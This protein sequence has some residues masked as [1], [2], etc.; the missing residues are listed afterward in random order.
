MVDF[1][2]VAVF[3]LQAVLQMRAGDAT[4][5]PLR[6]HVAH[7]PPLLPATLA[8]VPNIDSGIGVVGDGPVVAQCAIEAFDAGVA[9]F[10]EQEP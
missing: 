9:E 6:E 8:A 4:L 1:Y 5:V 7:L 2:G 10:G 3:V